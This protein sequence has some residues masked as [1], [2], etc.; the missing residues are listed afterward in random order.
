MKQ[1]QNSRFVQGKGG[2]GELSFI[3]DSLDLSLV[4]VEKR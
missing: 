3:D 4:Q 1:G 2:R